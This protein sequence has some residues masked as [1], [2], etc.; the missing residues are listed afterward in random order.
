MLKIK[1]FF[2]ETVTAVAV[3]S[4]FSLAAGAQQ[5]TKG[6]KESVACS[7]EKC[8][9]IALPAHDN[10]VNMTLMQAL[11]VRKSVR[12]YSE[13]EIS[14]QTLA[15]LLWAANGINR[16]DGKRT[17]PS[18]INAQ[19]INIYVCLKSGVYHF[20][21]ADNKLVMVVKE[22]MR[23][24]VCGRNS[25]GAKAPA[26]LVLVSDLSKFPDRI[27]A[28]PLATLDAGYV[29]QNICLYCAADGLATVPCYGK[30]ISDETAKKFIGSEKKSLVLIYHPVGYPAQ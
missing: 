21:P 11:Q 29:S 15:N 10:S 13:K 23:A 30:H 3:V 8:D 20:H 6:E 18:A 9:G 19:D 24:E 14:N 25:F 28:E 22:D 5:K 1:R 7:S 17:A 27:P 16:P 26:V 12:K 2:L 4:L